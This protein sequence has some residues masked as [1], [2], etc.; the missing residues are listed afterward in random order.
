[1]SADVVKFER[2]EGA[3]EVEVRGE[4]RALD[5]SNWKGRAAGF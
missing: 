1:M 4:V 2:K 5:P 3:S